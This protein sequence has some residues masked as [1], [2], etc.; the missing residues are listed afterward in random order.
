M[1][2]ARLVI[3]VILS[4]S[5]AAGAFAQDG[6]VSLELI[7]GGNGSGGLSPFSQVYIGIR[8]N[9][10]ANEPPG[11]PSIDWVGSNGFEIYSP[12]GADWGYLQGT[13][14]PL[15]S[16]LD[17]SVV[18]YLYHYQF[19]GTT[20][21]RT[22]NNGQDP[23]P[24]AG[25]I[26]R[27]GFYLATMSFTFKGYEG[28]VDNDI[29]FY[30]EFETSPDDDGLHLCIDTC[31]QITAWEWTNGDEDFPIWDNGLGYD[32]PRCWSIGYASPLPP[33]W[34]QPEDALTVSY[35]Q[36]ATYQ[37]CAYDDDGPFPLIYSLYPPFDNGDYGVVTPDGTWTWS[38]ATMQP[39]SY[40]IEFTVFDG[41]SNE[42]EVPFV[43]HVLVTETGCDCCLGRVGDANCS[44]DD[45]PT[46]GDIA[47]MIDRK[48]ILIVDPGWCC[49][50][51]ADIN[52]SGGTDPTPNDITIGDISILV[53]YLFITGPSLGLPN[54]L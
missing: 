48:F 42:S 52:Q 54:C 45:E 1:A 10:L 40:D 6:I 5:A 43:L 8:Y 14:G 11:D 20:W 29:A 35:C 47:Y 2:N 31:D 7:S 53:D 34:C 21:S 4:L 22:A 50:E 25:T 15:V 32:G 16:G 46:I 19:D 33:E 12:D 18:K 26:E 37:L 17:G 13:M 38:G 49:L 51:E 39:G 27:A 30:L 41:H 44:G 9:F 36:Q 24:G 3:T 28:G 23:C